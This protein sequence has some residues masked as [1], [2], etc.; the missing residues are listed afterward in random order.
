MKSTSA[1]GERE[2]MVI[3]KLRDSDAAERF[4]RERNM[5]KLTTCVS[6]INPGALRFYQ[7]CGFHVEGTL[8][9]HFFKG[10]DENQLA[11]FY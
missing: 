10:V 6:S 7:S 11:L 9:D 5:R 2:M 3:R 1:E 8:K 4:R